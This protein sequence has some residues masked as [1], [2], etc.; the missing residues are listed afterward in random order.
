[1]MDLNIFYTVLATAV[2]TLLGLLFIAIQP[3]IERLSNDP[4]NRWK[5]MATSTFHTYTLVL[6]MALF[7]LIPT[8]RTQALWIGSLFGMWRQLS[9]W[10]PVWRL[11]TQGRYARLREIFWM[12]VSPILI[13]AWLIFL[14]SVCKMQKSD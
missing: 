1:M 11:T 10:L 2:A 8:Y 7:T 5:A 9:T 4:Q 12:L 14:G 6:V 13:Y 3:N